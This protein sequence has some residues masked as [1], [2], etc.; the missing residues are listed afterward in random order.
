[1][2]SI[3]LHF[4]MSVLQNFKIDDIGLSKC[5]P[6]NDQVCDWAFETKVIIICDS[7]FK[8]EFL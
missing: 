6:K 8:N 7:F 3:D 4:L 2:Y 1:M 5:Q